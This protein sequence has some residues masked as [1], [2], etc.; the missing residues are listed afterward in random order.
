MDGHQCEQALERIL[1]FDL[2]RITAML[3]VVV[4]HTAGIFNLNWLTATY[5]PLGK[6]SA[7]TGLGGNLGKLGWNSSSSSA[8]A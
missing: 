6:I 1:M 3:M 4:Q 5:G 7:I 8:G 2:I